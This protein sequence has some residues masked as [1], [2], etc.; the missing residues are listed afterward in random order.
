M[1]SGFV[2]LNIHIVALL[3]ILSRYGLA[4]NEKGV[5]VEMLLVENICIDVHE[6]LK[7]AV[8]QLSL[9]LGVKKEYAD[10]VVLLLRV[11]VVYDDEE[12]S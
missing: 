3:H 4:S 7:C 2:D 6:F 11:L 1:D 5:L 10:Q 8:P 12:V 9:V